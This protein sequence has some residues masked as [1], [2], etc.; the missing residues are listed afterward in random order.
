MWFHFYIFLC[1]HIHTHTHTHTFLHN[2]KVMITPNKINNNPLGS[3]NNQSII[4][5]SCLPQKCLFILWLVCWTLDP[6]KTFVWLLP[7]GLL[8]SFQSRVGPLSSLFK[9]NANVTSLV[10]Q[11]VG[12]R[13]SNAGAPGSIPGWGTRSCMHAANK[14]SA[15]CN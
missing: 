5:F 12:L 15:C 13:T 8:R 2:P 6:G 7:L 1:T 4:K 11:W 14:K 10:V 9:F 3:S